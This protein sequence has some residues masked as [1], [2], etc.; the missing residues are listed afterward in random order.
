MGLNLEQPSSVDLPRVLGKADF[1]YEKS[2]LGGE[3]VLIFSLL[4]LSIQGTY[5]WKRTFLFY[6]L[7][8][9]WLTWSLSPPLPWL[10]L[11]YQQAK[12][13]EITYPVINQALLHSFTTFLILK[14]LQNH[15][16]FKSQCVFHTRHFL[17][18]WWSSIGKGTLSSG[19]PCQV[20]FF[21]PNWVWVSYGCSM[22]GFLLFIS[23]NATGNLW[24]WIWVH[25]N[26]KSVYEFSVVSIRNWCWELRMIVFVLLWQ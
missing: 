24:C 1:F 22:M 21:L 12:E 6:K 19:L 17:F 11:S 10:P 3:V 7:H 15:H 14:D 20:Y 16:W 5:S 18:C 8:G 26:E 23:S 4:A 25:E 13:L 9:D 2:D